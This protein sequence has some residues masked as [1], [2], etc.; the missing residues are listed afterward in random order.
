[1]GHSLAISSPQRRATPDVK[2]PHF[3]SRTDQAWHWPCT[4]MSQQTVC[5][6]LPNVR[7]ILHSNLQ[8]LD[9]E[10]PP[11]SVARDI[12]PLDVA[13]Q[14]CRSHSVFFNL[15]ARA[16]TWWRSPTPT[17]RRRP[18]LCPCSIKWKGGIL[19][20]TVQGVLNIEC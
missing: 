17:A 9:P 16:F 19:G 14:H 2:Q 15:L 6:I 20:K 5:V 10:Q 12:L 8:T 13:S 11:L 3:P 1:M 7:S 18:K 4:C